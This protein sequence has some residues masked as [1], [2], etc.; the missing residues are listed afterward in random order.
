L[1]YKYVAKEREDICV[2]Q[3]QWVEAVRDCWVHDKPLDFNRLA[4]TYRVPTLAGLKVC[5][6][7]FEDLSFRAQL[8]ENVIKHGGEYT[9]DLTKDV[10]HLIASKPEG[11][12]YEYGMQW[13]KK[14]VS[15]KWYKDTLERGMQ[16]EETLYHPTVPMEMQGAG[17]WNRKTQRSPS[18]AKRTRDD[19]TISEPARKLRRTASAKLGSQTQ[20]MWTDIVGGGFDATAPER[21]S[22]KNA[23]SMPVMHVADTEEK[24]MYEKAEVVGDANKQSKGRPH[25]GFLQGRWFAIVAFEEKKVGCIHGLCQIKIKICLHA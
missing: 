4:Q 14:V 1:K 10:T 3:P 15:L 5:I 20:N 9:G 6:T 7:G 13:Q 19:T 8:Q 12:K 18:T 2:L 21:P 22:L 16:L 24:N 17:A 23:V 25:H 11:K